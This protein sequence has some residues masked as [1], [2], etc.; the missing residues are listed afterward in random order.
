MRNAGLGGDDAWLAGVHESLR[1][2]AV[3][4]L[5]PPD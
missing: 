3:F 2:A 5:Q 4:K 1:C